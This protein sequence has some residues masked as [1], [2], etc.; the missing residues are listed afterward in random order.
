MERIGKEEEVGKAGRAGG[1]RTD[2]ISSYEGDT[3]NKSH[4]L[5]LP[6]HIDG[7]PAQPPPVHEHDQQSFTPT[8]DDNQEE[9]EVVGCMMSRGQYFIR[10][11][12]SSGSVL[13]QGQFFIRTW[14][15]RYPQCNLTINLVKDIVPAGFKPPTFP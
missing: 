15:S 14:H 10:V 7:G 1:R 12:S 4:E 9:R 8:E 11:S 13:H 2:G 3:L 5:P 6:L